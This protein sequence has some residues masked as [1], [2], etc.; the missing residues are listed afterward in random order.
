MNQ[1]F[2]DDQRS[3]YVIDLL[4]LIDADVNALLSAALAQAFG[5]R[6]C[7]MNGS[8]LQVRGHS[9]ATVRPGTLLGVGWALRGCGF[10][11][12]GSRCVL[13]W[14]DV[15]EQIALVGIKAFG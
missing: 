3:R 6:Q 7:M 2:D 5:F 13:G 12:R 15:T 11:G 1:M 14:S 4:A 9:P 8:T 10:D